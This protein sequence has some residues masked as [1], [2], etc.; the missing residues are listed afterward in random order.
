MMFDWSDLR[1]FLAVAKHGSTL[2]AAR[3]LGVNQSTVHRRIDAL[4]RRI[5]HALVRR[6]PS[7]YQLTEFGEALLPA[8][9][10]VENA[11]IAV[12]RQVQAYGNQLDGVIRLT[13]PEP[14]VSRITGSA[15]L[16]LFQERY[17]ALRIEFVMSDRYLDL[18][19]GEADIALRSGEPDD[20]NLV[21][22]K[23]GDSIWAVYASRSYVQQHGK[24]QRVEDI[25]DH[26]IIG[27]D[28]TLINH[29]AAKWFAAVA[30]NARIAARNN[31]VL[32]VLHAVKS[33]VG[34]APLP[35]A[36]ADMHDDL[37]QVLPPVQELGRGWYLLAHPDVRKTP[38]IRAFFD[39][40]T[41]KLD[42]VRPILMG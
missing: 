40:V 9:Q 32:G 7:G 28:G 15:L 16:E 26:A 29:R 6:H 22:R 35:T 37:V 10:A 33:G 39:F 31:S 4:E 42:L 14:L 30:P 11:A 34:V 41:E 3:A 17:P 21:G 20:E 25:A 12:E 2:A 38:Q 24:P 18:S 8:A 5:G 13:C 1:H 36:I 23:I 19:K 27:F